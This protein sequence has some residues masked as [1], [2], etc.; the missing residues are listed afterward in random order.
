MITKIFVRFNTDYQM[1]GYG[2]YNRY[3]F[4]PAMMSTTTAYNYKEIQK[5][6]APQERKEAVDRVITNLMQKFPLH[7]K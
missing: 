7:T 5:H 2:R 4:S 3:G 6:D 1:M